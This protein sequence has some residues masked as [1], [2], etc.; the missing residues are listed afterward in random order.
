VM[1]TGSSKC[2]EADRIIGTVIVEEE[3]LGLG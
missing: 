1:L 2:K 3:L